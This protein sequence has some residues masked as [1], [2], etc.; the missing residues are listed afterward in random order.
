MSLKEKNISKKKKKENRKEK[1]FLKKVARVK[2]RD[3]LENKYIT[4]P[5]YQRLSKNL[6]ILAVAHRIVTFA[7]VLQ[8][9]GF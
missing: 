5:L 9:R 8:I 4:R 1:I 7:D 2:F 3:K 6:M